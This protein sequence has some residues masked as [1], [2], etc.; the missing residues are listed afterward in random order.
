MAEDTIDTAAKFAG[1][2]PKRCITETLKLHGF[3]P[4]GSEE[5]LFLSQ[6]GKDKDEIKKMEEADQKLKLKISPQFPYT[7][8][9]ILWSIKTESPQRLEDIMARRTRALFLDAGESIKISRRVA[10][11]MANHMDK[12]QAWIDKEVEDFNN[13][14]KGY[15]P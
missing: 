10:E 12:D 5:S 9:E 15:L 14:A 2:K 1:L 13:L 8:A 7:Y 4:K 11:F 6:F 3:D